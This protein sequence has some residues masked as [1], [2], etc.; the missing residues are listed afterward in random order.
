MEALLALVGGKIGAV[1]LF[2]GLPL[3]F[4]V[5][6]K[7]LPKKIGA[8]FSSAL[9]RGFA[10]V[11]KMTDPIEKHLVMNIVLDVVKWAEY[12]IPDAGKGGDRYQLAAGKL[13]AMLPFLK[14]QDAKIAGLI[15]AA[16][17]AMDEELKKKI[18]PQP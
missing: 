9:G 1:G 13:C 5:L 6:K 18:P 14:G 15:E 4:V 2:V 12:K 10:D 3:L 8:F 17:M 7:T 16:V 11:D